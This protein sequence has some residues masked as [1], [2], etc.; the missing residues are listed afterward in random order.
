MREARYVAAHELCH[1]RHMDHSPAFWD[2]V[3][4]IVPEYPLIRKG[5]RAKGAVMKWL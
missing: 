1:T 4:K 2:E 5:M 3:G